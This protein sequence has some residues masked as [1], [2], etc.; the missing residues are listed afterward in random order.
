MAS[1]LKRLTGDTALYGLSSILG[2]VLNFVLVPIHTKYMTE[3]EYGVNSDLY[4]ILAFLMVLLT[5]GFETGFFRFSEKYKD[6]KMLVYAT[7]TRSIITTTLIFLGIIYLLQV[8]ILDALRY[9]DHPEYL[10]M[11]L[12]IISADVMAAV[13]MAKLRSERRAK[14]FVRNRMV[15]IVVNVLLNV[16]FFMALPEM[17][18]W[19]GMLGDFGRWM[20]DP[21]VKVGYVLLANLI[22][23]AFMLLDLI[24]EF[25]KIR[26]GFDKAI[27]REMLFFSFPLMLAGLAGVANEMIDRQFIKYL[28]PE[29]E[30]LE[31][32][33]IYS[34]VYKLSIALVLFNQ[35]FRY[36]AEP[37]FFEEGEKGR[38]RTIFAQILRAFTVVMCLGL[39]SVLAFS[40]LL[41]E[42]FLKNEDLWAG[43]EILP[44]L[45][46]ANVF[47]G[48]HTNMSIWYKLSD[49]TR[50]GMYITGIGLVFTVVMNLLLIPPLG[51]MGAAY[52]TLASYAAMAISSYAF[53]QIHYP[54]PYDVKTILFYLLISSVLGYLAFV[55]SGVHILI[56]LLCVLGYI[57]VVA[58][59]ERE[60]IM[61]IVHRLKG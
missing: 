31:Q 14:R 52:A 27:W 1:T 11:L 36:A 24:P 29:S 30:S 2:R 6:R 58:V 23:N 40:D 54:I 13:P 25:W 12:F 15:V 49:Q 21:E 22:A 32:L 33:G 50:Y 60:M 3:S 17:S 39:V 48:I 41:K 10:W 46:I 61:K 42:L 7:A 16:F 47:L 53:G 18:T 45:L 37:L 57:A 56:S 38:D 19:D 35:A 59:V 8:P 20:Y 5:Y 26:I 51:I 9:Q 34:G 55:Y 44:V 4:S 43:M 28:L